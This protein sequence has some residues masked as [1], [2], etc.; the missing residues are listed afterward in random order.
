MLNNHWQ[1]NVGIH[2]K[3]IP[4][5][6]GQRS[7]HNKTAGEVQSH[8]KSNL[9]PTRDAWRT[10]TKP[11]VHQDLGEGAVNPTRKWA[12]SAFECFRVSCGIMGQMACHRDKS[13]GSSSWD[14]QLVVQVPLE[15][16]T[17]NPTI[18]PPGG[19]STNG[20]IITPKKILHCCKSSRPHNRLPNLGIQQRDWESP[21][22][23]TLK[24]SRIWLQYFHRTRGK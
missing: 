16:V 3:R 14:A 2:Q 5:I 6:Q 11:C 12:R 23:L 9:V 17:I 13:S 15:D 7:S 10:Q 20:R 19:W 22:N 18:E 4:H 8:L 1:E 21:G 24:V